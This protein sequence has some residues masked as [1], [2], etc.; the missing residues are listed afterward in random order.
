MNLGETDKCMQRLGLNISVAF[1]SVKRFIVL[2]LWQILQMYVNM[3]E[4]EKKKNL[5]RRDSVLLNSIN[6]SFYYSTFKTLNIWPWCLTGNNMQIKTSACRY[7]GLKLKDVFR[8]N[9]EIKTNN[10]PPQRVQQIKLKVYKA[11]RNNIY[12]ETL[13]W[14]VHFHHPNSKLTIQALILS[15]K[16][17]TFVELFPSNIHSSSY[18]TLS[19]IQPV[20]HWLINFN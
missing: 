17:K 19:L 4:G 2:T 9:K 15:F 16:K 10:P 5:I 14:F 12:L 6:I 1:I 3:L 11:S 8:F 18:L 20:Q 7:S 13:F